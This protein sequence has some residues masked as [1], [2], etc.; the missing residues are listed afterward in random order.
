MQRSR[1]ETGLWRTREETGLLTTEEKTGDETGLH[2]ALHHW[3][4]EETMPKTTGE[5]R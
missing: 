1:E 2:T 3:R 4:G 5:K